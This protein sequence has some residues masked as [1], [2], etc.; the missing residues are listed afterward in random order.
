M[1]I[2]PIEKS[3]WEY[4]LRVLKAAGKKDVVARNIW[5]KLAKIKKEKVNAR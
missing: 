4:M 1:Y 5:A 2:L 3:G